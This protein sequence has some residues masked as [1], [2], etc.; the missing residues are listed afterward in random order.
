MTL[1]MAD[2]L[3]FGNNDSPDK[4]AGSYRVKV[5]AAYS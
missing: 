2:Y 4:V 5:R 1:W 3:S